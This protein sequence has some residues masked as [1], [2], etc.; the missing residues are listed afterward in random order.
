MYRRAALALFV[1]AAPLTCAVILPTATRAASSGPRTAQDLVGSYALTQST[2]TEAF[3]Q[4]IHRRYPD[5]EG[6]WTCPEA[7]EIEPGKIICV[8]E[9]HG[10]GR[11]H[12]LSAIAEQAGRSVTFSN[13]TESSWIRHWT[14]YSRGIIRSTGVPG[15][16]SVNGRSAT[17]WAW[18]AAG[19]LGF[20]PHRRTVWVDSYDGDSAGFGALVMFKCH[21]S[22][23]LIRCRN[24]LGDAMRYRPHT[25]G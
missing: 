24:K 13:P 5:A 9:F 7:Q 25:K 21:R 2:A 17:D 12:S 6:I 4:L 8:S 23:R 14:T 20:R 22:R 16:A 10:G 1:V 11:W 3:S 19:A 15:E 18:L